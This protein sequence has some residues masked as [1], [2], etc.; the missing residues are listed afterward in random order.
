ML[1]TILQFFNWAGL[2]LNTSKCGALSMINNRNRKYVEP[3]EPQVDEATHIPALKWEDSYKYLG[4][5]LGRERRGTMDDLAQSMSNAAEKICSSALTDWQKTDAVNTFVIPKACYHLDSAMLNITWASR[6]D[7]KLR[8]LVKKALRLPTR[9]TSAFLYTSKAHGGLGLRSVVDTLHTSRVSRLVSCLTSRDKTVNDVAWAQ[10]HLTVQKRRRL[11]EVSAED[12]TDFLNHP[13]LP[14]ERRT[15][16][17]STIWSLARKSLAH[18]SSSLEIDGADVVLSVEGEHFAPNQKQQMKKALN[19]ACEARHLAALLEAP[20]QGRAFHLVSK[21]PVSSHWIASGAYTSFSDF[22]FALRARLNLLP[23]KTVAKRVGHAIADD[24]CPKC[25]SAPETLG[26]ILNTCPPN[27]GLMRERHG[28]I[29]KRLIKATPTSAGNKFAEQ[30]IKDS[31]GDLRPDLVVLNDESSTAVIVD[32]T[33][34]IETSPS[35]FDAAREEKLRKYTPLAEWLTTQGYTNVSTHAFIVGSL[36]SW[37]P[38]NV[39]ALKALS[40]GRRYSVLMSKLCVVDAI[41]GSNTIWRQRSKPRT[42][43]P[44]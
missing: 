44:P 24:T 28:K 26:H 15:N 39:Q 36:G 9:T 22:R 30:K 42:A 29:L 17:V 38:D 8:R 21:D 2:E 3:F 10:L 5:Q 12:I 6:V 11:T 13:P 35:S 20:D 7:A 34:P 43:H 33:I 14:Q 18:A 19:N 32:V 4:V 23:T 40:I 41:N 27:A 37:D 31:P 16:D 1:K 25:R